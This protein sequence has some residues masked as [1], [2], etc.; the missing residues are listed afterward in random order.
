LAPQLSCAAESMRQ[1]AERFST[2]CDEP[3]AVADLIA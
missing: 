2:H 1:A 3:V